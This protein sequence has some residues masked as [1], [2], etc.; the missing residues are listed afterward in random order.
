M[1]SNRA[2]DLVVRVGFVGAGAMGRPMVERL[3][4]AGHQVS[5]FA[6]RPEVAE[7]LGESGAVVAGTAAAVAANAELVLLCPFTDGQVHQIAVDDGLLAAMPG[8]SVLGIHTTGSPRTAEA[9]ALA[10]P[11]AVGVIDA[12]VSGSPAS[13]AAGE[14]TLFVGGAV[15]HVERA[16]PALASYGNPIWHAG[17]LGSGQ[18][19]K[20]VN[21]ALFAAHL[22]LASETSRIVTELGLDPIKSAGALEHGSGA[23]RAISILGGRREMG[24]LRTFLDKDVN[25]LRAVSAELQLDLGLLAATN[26]AGPEPFGDTTAPH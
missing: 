22:Q 25:V 24:T 3:L 11:D 19:L 23:S 5:V 16:R 18:A 21:N 17:R 12:P 10:A 13:V 1:A 2:Y 8:G 15:G 4:G 14:I 26:A 7:A 6:R 20:L 9:L